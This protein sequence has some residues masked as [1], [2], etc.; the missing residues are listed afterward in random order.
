MIRGERVY[1]T[2]IDPE[3]AE[4][5]RGW[6]ND[7]RVNHW[8]IAGHVP[9]SA[10]QEKD[11]LEEFEK[12]DSVYAYEIHV[13]EDDRLIGIVDLRDVDLRHRT[14]TLGIMIGELDEHGKGYGRDALMTMMRFGFETL[15]LHHIDIS[16]IDGNEVSASLYP[17]LGFVHIGRFRERLWAHGGFRD[18]VEFDM[19][20]QEFFERYGRTGDD[21]SP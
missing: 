4:T 11:T 10:K 16:Y 6:I 20:D 7:P 19:L 9:V 14:G 1:L 5:F 17:S 3:H 2:P 15:G 18:T 21:V 12:S 13:D 8:L